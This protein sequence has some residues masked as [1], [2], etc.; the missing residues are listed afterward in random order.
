M[1]KKRVDA[2]VG[3]G[4]GGFGQR[5]RRRRRRRHDVAERDASLLADDADRR[6]RFGAGTLPHQLV[7]C[8]VQRKTSSFTSYRVLPSFGFLA[9]LW[10]LLN[11]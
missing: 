3:G 6:R 10:T 4:G 11:D 9:K 5:R 7:A 2:P 1:K 8:G